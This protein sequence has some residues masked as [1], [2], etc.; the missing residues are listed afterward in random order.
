MHRQ[1]LSFLLMR[2]K[3]AL[4]TCTGDLLAGVLPK[5]SV[6]RITNCLNMTAGVDHEC[7]VFNQPTDK[8]LNASFSIGKITDCLNMTIA[9]DH[10][11]KPF[12]QP[13]DKCFNATLD[14]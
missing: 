11:C 10:G 13:T 12:N 8:C 4:I 3:C 7:K 9:V 14:T 1:K 5:N 2:L 6:A